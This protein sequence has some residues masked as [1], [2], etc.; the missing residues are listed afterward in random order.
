MIGEGGR[1]RE[2]A[3]GVACCAGLFEVGAVGCSGIDLLDLDFGAGAGFGA[4]TV[5]GVVVFFGGA[6]AW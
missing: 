6:I 3:A 1:G 4:A 2:R 5:F